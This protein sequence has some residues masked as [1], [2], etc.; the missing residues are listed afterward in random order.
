MIVGV[1]IVFVV[2]VL[3]LYA[4]R[5]GP[6][7]SFSSA[8][9]SSARS[10]PQVVRSVR[11][12][13]DARALA[14]HLAAE[15]QPMLSIEMPQWREASARDRDEAKRLLEQRVREFA[16]GVAA[17]PERLLMAGSTLPAFGPLAWDLPASESKEVVALIS[18]IAEGKDIDGQSQV[19]LR[20]FG[21]CALDAVAVRL[22]EYAE[23]LVIPDN[24]LRAE[25]LQ[26]FLCETTGFD[27]IR[28]EPKL[29]QVPAV[30]RRNQAAPSLWRWFLHEF[31]RDDQTWQSYR[32][33][34]GLDQR[35]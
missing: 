30:A 13:T 8:R 14:P 27:A 4:V 6:R 7:V 35:R 2:G 3:A 23:E 22:D 10:A 34:R 26:Q 25:R 21:R 20:A 32:E 29:R 28:F 11:S 1:A 9:T 5:G 16:A 17:D 12:Y 33:L 18:E 19:R 24:R 15:L 31:A